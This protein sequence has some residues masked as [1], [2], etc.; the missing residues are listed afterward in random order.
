MNDIIADL[1]EACSEDGG[2]FKAHISKDF[3]VLECNIKDGD[4]VKTARHALDI[5]GKHIH[6]KNRKWL[7]YYIKNERDQSNTQV[8]I[9]LKGPTARLELSVYEQRNM[10][11][12]PVSYTHLTLPTN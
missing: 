4:L 8:K 9:S 11:I 12:P 6:I 1:R 5:L 3:L 10:D 2:K 7:S